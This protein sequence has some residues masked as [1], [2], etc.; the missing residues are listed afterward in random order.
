MEK[1]E[2]IQ[3][4][5]IRHFRPTLSELQD[6]CRENYAEVLEHEGFL[7]VSYRGDRWIRVIGQDILQS[8]QFVPFYAAFQLYIGCQPFFLPAFFPKAERGYHDCRDRFFDADYLFR[9]THTETFVYH[10]A[11]LSPQ[12]KTDAVLYWQRVIC[13]TVLPIL[14]SITDLS[15]CHT[16]YEKNMPVWDFGQE[17][18]DGRYLLECVAL[19]DEKACNRILNN[20]LLPLLRQEGAACSVC[21]TYEYARRAG[22]EKSRI[23][24]SDLVEDLSGKKDRIREWMRKTCA[25]TAMLVNQLATQSAN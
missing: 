23:L 14:N 17:S 21:L 5:R 16:W 15:S 9:K 11:P 8:V 22:S 20:V 10:A 13:E 25:E 24:V 19:Q 12:S 6:Y 3:N 4:E 7:R 2:R 1:T 18:F